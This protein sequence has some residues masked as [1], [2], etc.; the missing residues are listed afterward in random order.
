MRHMICV[1][2]V[3]ILPAAVLAQD[4]PAKRWQLEVGGGASWSPRGGDAPAFGSSWAVSLG[5]AISPYVTIRL[6][7]EGSAISGFQTCGFFTPP[8][9]DPQQPQFYCASHNGAQF[10]LFGA[11]I[12]LTSHQDRGL[13]VTARVGGYQMGA[14]SGVWPGVY[15]GA[16]LAFPAPFGALVIE[17]GLHGYAGAGDAQRSWT[18][19]VRMA[20][21]LRL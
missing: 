4:V 18:V 9:P 7:S 8:G 20:L 14:R 16:G 2:L 10:F 13:F 11:G 19:P 5:R 1:A 12:D 6:V 3:S 17:T 15:A 21:R